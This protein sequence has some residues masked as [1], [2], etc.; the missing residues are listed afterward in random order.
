MGKWIDASRSIGN[1]SVY[2]ATNE[3]TNNRSKESKEVKAY[4]GTNEFK[5]DSS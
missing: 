5:Q 3:K 2:P 4:Y 1:I